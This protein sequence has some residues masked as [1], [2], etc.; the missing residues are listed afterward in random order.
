MDSFAPAGPFGKSKSAGHEQRIPVVHDRDVTIFSWFKTRQA[1]RTELYPSRQG[2]VDLALSLVDH[3]RSLVDLA[4][5][6][7]D[8]AYLDG[9]PCSGAGGSGRGTGAL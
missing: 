2:M 5:G 9:G 6:T 4:L 3:A 8:L 7:V 1:R